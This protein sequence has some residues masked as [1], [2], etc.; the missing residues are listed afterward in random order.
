MALNRMSDPDALYAGQVLQIEMAAQATGP[1][2]RAIPESEVVNGPAYVGFD[3]GSEIPPSSPILGYAEVVDGTTMSGMEIVQRISSDFSVGPRV[4]L[5]QLEA[6]SGAVSGVNAARLDQYPVG[7]VDPARTGLWRQL[8]WF[9][10]RLNRGFYDWRGRDSRLMVTSD[11]TPMAG[12]P[13]LGPGS[14]ALQSALAPMGASVDLEASL[15]AFSGAYE[16]LYGDPWARALPVP[17]PDERTFPTL[18]LPWQGGESWWFTGGP[19]GGWADGSAW[20]ALDFVPPD[21]ALACNVSPAW[22]VAVADGV[23]LDA[24]TGAIALDLDG[25]GDRRTGPVVFLL[26]VAA[27]DRA[28]I[29]ARVEA[30]DRLGHPSCEGGQSTATH[31]HLARLYDGEW[32]DARTPEFRMGG[33]RFEGASQEYD[34]RAVGASGDVREPCE[35]REEG[36]NDLGS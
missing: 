35:C 3:L 23:V 34:G 9:A 4:L 24:G 13:E 5:A 21:D 20:S 26:H 33:W 10:D 36:E 22:V 17:Y 11:G 25:D 19:H 30:G 29:G 7:L 27:Q 15:A 14:F 8:N 31:L 1:A 2:T 12:H 16:R 32:M 18:R 6:A 28:Q